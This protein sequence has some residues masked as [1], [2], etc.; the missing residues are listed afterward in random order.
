MAWPDAWST[1]MKNQ[2][3]LGVHLDPVRSA[4]AAPAFSWILSLS[5]TVW[6]T[7]SATGEPM[8]EPMSALF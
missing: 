8:T 4:V 5:L 6:L 3:L 1:A 2:L 7:A